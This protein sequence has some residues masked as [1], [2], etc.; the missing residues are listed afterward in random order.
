V[1][2]ATSSVTE[3]NSGWRVCLRVVQQ[4]DRRTDGRLTGAS[5]A[6]QTLTRTHQQLINNGRQAPDRPAAARCVTADGRRI[7]DC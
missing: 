1:V 2:G 4:T 5:T 3:A 6:K 7:N